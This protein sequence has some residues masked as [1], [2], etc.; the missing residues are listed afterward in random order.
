MH[1]FTEARL[2]RQFEFSERKLCRRRRRIWTF[3]FSGFRHPQRSLVASPKQLCD[4]EVQVLMSGMAMR[5]LQPGN[6]GHKS[7]LGI[8]RANPPGEQKPKSE[9]PDAL[10]PVTDRECTVMRIGQL[11]EGARWVEIILLWPATNGVRRVIVGRTH[12][13]N[14]CNHL[15]AG[16]PEAQIRLGPAITILRKEC[17][18]KQSLLA[19]GKVST[20]LAQ[21]RPK[22]MI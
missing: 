20:K 13:S 22:P 6:R 7:S 11:N 1:E 2:N 5:F 4:G 18:W 9:C 19:S 10:A 8:I 16:I 15:G 14:L 12:P 21:N 17:C 3:T